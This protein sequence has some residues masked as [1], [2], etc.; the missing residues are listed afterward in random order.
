MRSPEKIFLPR[1]SKLPATRHPSPSAFMC[2]D[3][4][5][6]AWRVPPHSSRVAVYPH[7]QRNSTNLRR[8]LLTS[9]PEG[10]RHHPPLPGASGT[11]RERR[12]LA[13]RGTVKRCKMARTSPILDRVP[14]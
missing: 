2:R 12:I 10:T 14:A 11:A 13:R 5:S 9:A 1:W 7:A 3:I 8:S 4:A 6:I